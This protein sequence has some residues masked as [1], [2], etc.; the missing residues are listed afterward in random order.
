MIGK[1][2]PSIISRVCSEK[3][4]KGNTSIESKTLT[5][6]KDGEDKYLSSKVCRN[7]FS[8]DMTLSWKGQLFFCSVEN[9]PYEMCA[10]IASLSLRPC[11]TGIMSQSL[12]K[13]AQKRPLSPERCY[14]WVKHNS[15]NWLHSVSN[16]NF[17]VIFLHPPTNLNNLDMSL[18]VSPLKHTTKNKQTKSK[19]TVC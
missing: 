4:L 11:G 1:K 17:Y 12:H 19:T 5:D 3:H 7:V 13:R 10:A 8:F 16:P 15:P 14:M 2:L 18:P 6:K 9:S